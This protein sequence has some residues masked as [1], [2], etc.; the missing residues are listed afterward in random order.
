MNDKVDSSYFHPPFDTKI[1]STITPP[2]ER[3]AI[4]PG[5]SP[6]PIRTLPSDQDKYLLTHGSTCKAFKKW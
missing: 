2:G 4:G 5:I 6:I 3:I 1:L